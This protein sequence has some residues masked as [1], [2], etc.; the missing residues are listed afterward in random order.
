MVNGKK[1]SLPMGLNINGQVKFM[2]PLIKVGS[3]ISAQ[4]TPATG[5]VF[6]GSSSVPFIVNTVGIKPVNEFK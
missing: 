6:L 2:T 4:Y 5:S 1:V 3:Q